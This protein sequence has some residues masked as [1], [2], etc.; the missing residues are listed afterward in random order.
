MNDNAQKLTATLSVIL[1]LAT[2]VWG[3]WNLSEGLESTRPPEVA[4][5]AY[6]SAGSQKVIARL[7]QDPFEA[8]KSLTNG[9]A[10]NQSKEPPSALAATDST[11]QWDALRSELKRRTEKTNQMITILGV[12]LEGTPYPADAEVRRRL[13]YAVELAVLNSKFAPEDRNHIGVAAVAVTNSANAT[14]RLQLAFEWFQATP[15][16]SASER[17][18]LLVLW[19]REDDI[20]AEPLGTLDGLLACLGVAHTST[21]G[22]MIACTNASVCLVGPRSSDTLRA[23]AN[24][25]P[26]TNSPCC[27]L[28]QKGRFRIFSPEATA[29][30]SL[31]FPDHAG[32]V[33]AP[34][35]PTRPI[36]SQLLATNLAPDVF[37]NWIATDYQLA[38]LI[39]EE[40]RNR[41]KDQQLAP[42]DIIVL[43]SEAD[44][45]YGR[46]LPKAIELALGT[47][48]LPD[49]SFSPYTE[50]WRFGYL[51]GL[52]GTKAAPPEDAK[53]A[54]P[55]SPAA[56]PEA[57]VAAALK[58]SSEKA[59]GESQTD[60]AERLAGLLRRE[61]AQLR[62]SGKGRILA[63]GLTGSDVYDK[64]ILLRALRKKLPEA[65]F[66]ATDL[67]AL[68]WS[69]DELKHTRNLLVASAY[70][71]EPATGAEPFLPFRDGYQTAVYRACRSALG[72]PF[73]APNLEGDLYEIGRHG[74]VKLRRA[75][76]A[77][78]FFDESLWP[79]PAT[80]L[81]AL[82]TLVVVWFLIRLPGS[83]RAP[84][85]ADSNRWQA[86][87]AVSV[88]A[89]GAA[90][91][92][93]S[94][95]A[96]IVAER[97]GE[98]P[99]IFGEGISIWPT[100]MLRVLSILAAIVFLV[101]THEG[102]RRHGRKLWK[103]YFADEDFDAMLKRVG[104]KTPGGWWARI[105]DPFRTCRINPEPGKRVEARTL[106]EFYI[107]QG[108]TWRRYLRA[109]CMSV[110]YG[111]FLFLSVLAVKE[112]PDRL[113]I[114]GPWS[115]RIDLGTLGATVALFL[116]VLFYVLDASRLAGTMLNCL[117]KHRT[118]WPTVLATTHARNKGLGSADLEG[119]LDVQFAA[120]KTQETGRL[121]YYPFLIFLLLLLS[122]NSYFENW[123]WP[124]SLIAVFVLN[125][126]IAATCWALVR[127]SARH[128][129]REALKN[130]RDTIKRTELASEKEIPVEDPNGPAPKPGH[131]G[132]TVPC[133]RTVYLKRL[134]EL[135]DE[136]KNVRRGAFAHWIQDPTYIALFIPTGVTGILTVLVHY[137]LSRP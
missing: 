109:A 52:E 49:A 71:I 46:S 110:G 53:K 32:T 132:A 121:M 51:R 11:G 55:V 34:N 29:P 103:A 14:N 30:D 126:I 40:L 119:W 90:T 26:Q 99:W 27:E 116:L 57:V 76:A 67:D 19:L 61:E 17:S 136:I 89:L 88:A 3:V 12:T 35:A 50:L 129:Q 48:Q 66:F 100:E 38:E 33:Q 78:A 16:P 47:P 127:D 77:G 69:P 59:E 133:R 1:V 87:L 45:F 108:Q 118:A 113:C 122:R 2:A 97:P 114:R 73:I 130:L 37:T 75:S 91:V 83:F 137:W 10:A 15:T 60:Y 31:L 9:A 72:D 115:A 92:L 111:S 20:A 24:T 74:P 125:F 82:A 95:V 124:H 54:S 22:S 41:G 101:A 128:V 112:M 7:W 81:W 117:A 134:A 79:E 23:L 43:V 96:R 86:W 58:K 85:A 93:A 80:V 36:L 64:L 39:V 62:W 102:H 98:E 8:F 18:S 135:A 5:A 131:P 123:T 25:R 6:P 94:G 4:S 105:L 42:G 120:D 106:F 13:R 65:L 107:R 21:N 63:V 56:S 104:A 44:T 68:L 70:G 28:A 84:S